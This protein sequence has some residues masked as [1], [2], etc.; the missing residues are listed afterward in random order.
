M[1]LKTYYLLDAFRN[2]MIQ[3]VEMNLGLKFWIT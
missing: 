1:R 3:E 2:F